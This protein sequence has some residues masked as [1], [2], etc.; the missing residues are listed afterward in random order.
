MNHTLQSRDP[1]VSPVVLG[2]TDEVVSSPTTSPISN[3]G[4]PTNLKIP[5]IEVDTTVESVGED[6]E[7]RMDV[8]Q[9]WNNVAWYNRGT[10]PGRTGSAV[11]AGHLDSPTG[12]A[13]FFNLAKLEIGDEVIV[14]NDTG[15]ELTYLVTDKKT[16]PDAG[17]P[18]DHVFAQKD[19]KRLNL[20]TCTGVFNQSVKRYSDRLVVYTVLKE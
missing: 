2:E 15:E 7:G 13:I 4:Q 16:Y 9:E 8:P 5:A 17:F 18:I 3:F 12:P 14:T 6:A 20:I 1:F 19:A 10:E 11:L